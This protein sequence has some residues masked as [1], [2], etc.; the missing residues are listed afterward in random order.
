MTSVATPHVHRYTA[1]CSWTGTTGAGY[2]RYD[3]THD[4]SAP[5]ASASLTLSADPAFRGDPARLNPEQ[6]LVIAASSCQ[7]LSFLAVAARSRLDVLEYHDE[8]EAEMP[9]D[10]PPVR[11][12]AIRL[13][14]RIVASGTDAE[15]VR[16][17]VETAHRECYVANSVTSTVTVEPT[18]E[19][20]P[21]VLPPESESRR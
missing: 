4:A 13:R 20:R 12:S 10:D 18:V 8:A 14:P 16:R 5:P 19:V 2:A 1:R 17:C 15:R 7:L 21:A 6:L 3:R 11:I 9:E